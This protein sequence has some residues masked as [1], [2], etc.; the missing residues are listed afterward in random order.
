MIGYFAYGSNVSS[1]VMTSRI[2]SARR[3]RP[4]RLDGY[5]LV[6]SLPSVRW[7]GHAAGIE[8]APGQVVW[9]L[10]WQIGRDDLA[11]LDRV[12]ANY[13][14]IEV[15]PV[16]AGDPV[17]AV[18]YVVRPERSVDEGRPVAEYLGH[19]VAGAI[20]HGLPDPWVAWLREI[21]PV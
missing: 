9:G 20:E 13:H 12:E 6:F 11:L 5:R 3:P 21:R 8:P 16:V 14:R 2:P 15:T 18:S 1:G 17:P 7:G 4:A 19:L 10:V